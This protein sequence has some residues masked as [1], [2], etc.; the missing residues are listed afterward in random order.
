MNTYNAEEEW[1]K[2]YLSNNIM[3][4]AENV[5]RIFKGKYPNLSISDNDFT[6]KKICDI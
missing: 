1:T 3:Y 2:H 4:P 6:G 5:V